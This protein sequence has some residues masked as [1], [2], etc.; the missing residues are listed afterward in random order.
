MPLN[1]EISLHKI[2]ATVDYLVYD[3]FPFVGRVSAVYTIPTNVLKIY[4]K[5]KMC[6]AERPSIPK[7]KTERAITFGCMCRVGI[8]LFFC[9]NFNLTPK[10]NRTRSRHTQTARTFDMIQYWFGLL[11][12]IAL[13]PMLENKWL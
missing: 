12:Y 11:K 4:G 9:H 8:K 6:S 3:F 1:A 7:V 2:F 5:S 10:L 13:A